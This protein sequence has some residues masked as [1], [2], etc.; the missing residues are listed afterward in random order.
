MRLIRTLDSKG[1]YEYYDKGSKFVGFCLTLV[2]LRN[3]VLTEKGTTW[4]LRS[5]NW[6]TL[7]T[8]QVKK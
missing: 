2:S 7:P 5:D 6:K 8:V 4:L 3:G 1:L